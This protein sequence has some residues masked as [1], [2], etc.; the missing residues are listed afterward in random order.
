M[1]MLVPSLSA[2][3]QQL[4]QVH[5]LKLLDD[6]VDHDFFQSSNQTFKWGYMG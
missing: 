1:A 5:V 3:L 4:L 2:A 6:V